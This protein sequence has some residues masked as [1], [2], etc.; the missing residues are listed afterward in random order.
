M[1]TGLLLA[2][3]SPR[4][5]VTCE[6]DAALRMLHGRDVIRIKAP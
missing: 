6:D 4:T 5:A 2:W 1:D 3:A